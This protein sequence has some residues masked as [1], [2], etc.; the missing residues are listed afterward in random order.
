M[1]MLVL[2]NRHVNHI[3]IIKDKTISVSLSSRSQNMLKTHTHVFDLHPGRSADRVRVRA[4][5]YLIFYCHSLVPL[6]NPHTPTHSACTPWWNSKSARVKWSSH[7]VKTENK[8]ETRCGKQRRINKWNY[9]DKGGWPERREWSWK[10][11]WATFK[12]NME[13]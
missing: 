13:R 9:A 3:I 12:L 4:T 10:D 11:P 6:L 7:T 1:F 2:P 5:T 8:V